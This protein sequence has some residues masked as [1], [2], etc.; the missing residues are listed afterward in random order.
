[1]R[2]NARLELRR[3]A[4][5]ENYYRRNPSSKRSRDDIGNVPPNRDYSLV[6]VDCDH[7]WTWRTRESIDGIGWEQVCLECDAVERARCAHCEVEPEPGE[8]FCSFHVELVEREDF[9]APL[10][11]PMAKRTDGLQWDGF[12]ID[13]YASNREAILKQR[14]DDYWNAPEVARSRARA[15]RIRRQH[16]VSAYE[17]SRKERKAAQRKERNRERVL[18]VRT[19]RPCE[20]CQQQFE[21]QSLTGR[22]PRFCIS[23]ATTRKREITRQIKQAKRQLNASAA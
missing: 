1:M 12:H 16:Y 5:A 15:K 4:P 6:P 13:T 10:L 8:H 19:S 2:A 14:H 7:D 21:P 11:I 3:P 20:D 22:L 9:F 17:A 23:C 18:A